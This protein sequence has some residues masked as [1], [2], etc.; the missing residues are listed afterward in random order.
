MRTIPKRFNLVGHEVRVVLK[1]DLWDTAE[2]HGRWIAH[3][4]LIEL[5]KPT[6]Q[7]GMTFSFLLATF[8]HEC[9]HAIAT[10]MG[11]P[12]LNN[13]EEKIDL[14]GQGIAQILLTKRNK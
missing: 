12:D 6:K 4:N 2:C 1:N 9:G 11:M 7:N 5:Q 13:D 8:W 14:L 10:H 3:K